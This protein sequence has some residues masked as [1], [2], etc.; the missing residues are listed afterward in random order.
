M[1]GLPG[2]VIPFLVFPAERWGVSA[3]IPVFRFLHMDG[4]HAAVHGRLQLFNQIIRKGKG[5]A[6]IG[7]GG[8]VGNFPV[9]AAALG[10]IPV[11]FPVPVPVQ[12]ILVFTPGNARHEMHDV[13]LLAEGTDPFGHAGINA[14]HHDKVTAQINH[15]GIGCPFLAACQFR[16][17]GADIGHGFSSPA[18]LG[19]H[20]DKRG[21]M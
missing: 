6:H 16:M 2:L 7:H 19:M 8:V 20:T 15:G 17:R 14:V 12:V 9:I 18:W 5:R 11:L 4:F 10:F 13:S 21:Y 3:E 1:R